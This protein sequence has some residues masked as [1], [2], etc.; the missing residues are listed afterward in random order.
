MSK[1]I[2]ISLDDD[3]SKSLSEVLSNDTCKRILSFLA[4]NEEVTE[5]DIANK[6]KI[7]LNTVNYNMKKLLDSKL[8]D[9]AGHFF[10]S[11]KGKKIR[12]YRLSN[13]SILIS[14]KSK[15]RFNKV[16]TTLITV[17]S[18]FLLGL[19]IRFF[20]R[21]E[22]RPI[23]DNFYATSEAAIT[24]TQ[25]LLSD[26]SAQNISYLS[27]VMSSIPSWGWFLGGGLF[28]LIIILALNWRKL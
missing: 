12:V 22:I 3:S 20:F 6:L 27:S 7:P 13:K 14:P 10:W 18:T 15:G 17:G 2:M 25:K 28:A 5:S 4:D 11:K 26:G 9:E 16:L 8:V 1:H 23:E 21:S 19:A 24:T